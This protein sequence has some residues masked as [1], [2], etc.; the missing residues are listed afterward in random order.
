MKLSKNKNLRLSE[1]FH[2]K[3]IQNP[4]VSQM[5]NALCFDIFNLRCCF[6]LSAHPCNA[7]P[8]PLPSFLQPYKGIWSVGQQTV[9][10]QKSRPSLANPC[11][12]SLNSCCGTCVSIFIVLIERCGVSE[13]F[14]YDVAQAVS[15]VESQDGTTSHA[16]SN[17]Q[18][19]PVWTNA[20]T[21]T[22]TS[23]SFVVAVGVQQHCDGHSDIFW[24]SCN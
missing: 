13:A 7:L 21:H 12:F 4:R 8:S 20:L 15:S 6:T 5:C 9:G 1:Y 22:L 24:A 11:D 16:R 19:T 23:R 3:V 10:S 2:W 17:W 18:S 14:I